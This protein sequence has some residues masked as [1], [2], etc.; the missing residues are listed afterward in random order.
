MNALVVLARRCCW[1]SSSA[2]SARCCILRWAEVLGSALA[3]RLVVL[4]SASIYVLALLAHGPRHSGRV[5]AALAWMGLAGLLLV[6]NPP[7]LCGCCCR[8]A[9]FWLLRSLRNATTV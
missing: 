3:L 7:L 1:P 8:P 2:W 6:F 9:S 5:V 4:G